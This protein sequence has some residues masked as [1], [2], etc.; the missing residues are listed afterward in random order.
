MSYFDIVL[1]EKKKEGKLEGKIEGIEEKANKVIVK[2]LQAGK[3]TLEE[4]ADLTDKD[5][6]YV[7]AINAKLQTGHL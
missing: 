4:I 5:L 3:L 7:Q 2:A 6:A 1:E